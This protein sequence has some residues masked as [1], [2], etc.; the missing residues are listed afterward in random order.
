MTLKETKERLLTTAHT[1][2][3]SFFLS[4]SLYAVHSLRPL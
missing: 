1:Q 2:S 4:L 3:L